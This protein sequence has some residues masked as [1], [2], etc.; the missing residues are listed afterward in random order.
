VIDSLGD[1][2]TDRIP[3]A[4]TDEAKTLSEILRAFRDEVAQSPWNRLLKDI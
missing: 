1:R 4:Q 3:V 2:G